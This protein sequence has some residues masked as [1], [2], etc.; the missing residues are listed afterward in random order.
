[1]FGNFAQHV[2]EMFLGVSSLVLPRYTGSLAEK[3]LLK[4]GNTV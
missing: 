3:D 4:N 1:M 2:H